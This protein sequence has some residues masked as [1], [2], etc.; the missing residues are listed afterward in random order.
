MAIGISLTSSKVDR[1]WL[2]VVGGEGA[3]LE[4]DVNLELAF[5]RGSKNKTTKRLIAHLFGK[6]RQ[7]SPDARK[8]DAASIPARPGTRY[9]RK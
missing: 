8:A 9:N 3:R 7:S 6:G 2:R 1:T 5:H 4:L